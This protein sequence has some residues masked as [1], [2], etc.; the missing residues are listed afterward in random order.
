MVTH[1]CIEP[2]DTFDIVSEDGKWTA[3]EEMGECI[4]IACQIRAE[5]F[6][7]DMWLAVVDGLNAL[8]VMVSSAVRK[9]ISVDNCNDCVSQVHRFDSIG[10]V[11]WFIRICLL[12]T[13]DAADE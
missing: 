1:G 6:E 8:L 13:S 12:Y 5:Q 2:W 4:M 9:V 3:I 7:R 10:K 11:G